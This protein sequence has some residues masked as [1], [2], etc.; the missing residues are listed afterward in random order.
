MGECVTILG[1]KGR[2]GNKGPGN[3]AS[4]LYNFTVGI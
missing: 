4:L 2:H 1:H 3:Q